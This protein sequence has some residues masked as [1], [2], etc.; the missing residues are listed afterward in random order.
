MDSLPQ[1][2]INRIARFLPDAIPE[3]ESYPYYYPSHSGGVYYSVPHWNQAGLYDWHQQEPRTQLASYSVTSTAWRY[4]VEEVIYEEKEI[5]IDSD[6]FATFC[7][8]F[9][10]SQRHKSLKKLTFAIRFPRFTPRFTPRFIRDRKEATATVAMER[11]FRVLKS[12]ESDMVGEGMT[13]L[14]GCLAFDHE[15]ED[16]KTHSYIE[17]DW[18]IEDGVY[19]QTTSLPILNHVTSFQLFNNTFELFEMGGA[20]RLS[21][22]L[23]NLTD[24][25][26]RLF[27]NEL[28][29]WSSR[30]SSRH[31][32]ARVFS[33][34]TFP[35]L[36]TVFL[37]LC[38]DIHKDHTKR[39]PNLLDQHTSNDQQDPVS[40]SIFMCLSQSQN[41]T[42]MKIKGVFNFSLWWPLSCDDSSSTPFPCLKEVEVVFDLTMPSGKWYFVGEDGKDECEEKELAKL[43]IENLNF[44]ELVEP[45][46]L[47][48]FI[49]AFAKR[50]AQL[51]A[52]RRA[53]LTT[54]VQ[55]GGD[56]HVY[57]FEICYFAPGESAVHC[58]EFQEGD[59]LWASEEESDDEEPDDEDCRR[60]YL[61]TTEFGMKDWR[62]NHEAM[63]YFEEVGRREYGGELII[64]EFQRLPFLYGRYS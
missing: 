39:P 44:R 16:P 35:Q 19:L 57:E 61:C 41:L 12:W 55:G 33:N 9:R 14:V 34:T 32:F 54:G 22:K 42:S 40:K 53:I 2:V 47:N 3:P 64:K 4:A 62:P 38:T 43:R 6:E 56:V 25:N 11:L 27:D 36:K 13:L 31:E 30:R 58:T 17:C 28:K 29:C 1:E 52:L 49:L 24:L 15:E 21:T 23:P 10:P 37:D 20:A 45:S 60:L 18:H 7:D 63:E 59:H 5:S 26:M 51:P 48:P 50:L 8:V 46:C